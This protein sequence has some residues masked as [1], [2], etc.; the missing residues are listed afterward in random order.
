MQKYLGS[1][2]GTNDFKIQELIRVIDATLGDVNPKGLQT[3]QN[4]LSIIKFLSSFPGLDGFVTTNFLAEIENQV[5]LSATKENVR[6][7]VSKVLM[8]PRNAYLPWIDY[9]CDK[10][11]MTE[12]QQKVSEITFKI[13]IVE[14][15]VYG[16]C[17]S[18]QTLNQIVFAH[19]KDNLPSNL[20]E[21]NETCHVTIINSN[22]VSDVGLEKVESFIQSFDTEF[23]INTGEIKST[24]SEDWSRFS[25]CYVVEITCPYIDSF[26]NSFNET[27]GKNIK[28]AKHITFAIKPRSLWQ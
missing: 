18:K 2:A 4:A 28:I 6:E 23:C 11:L 24:F 15:K 17:Q 13:R 3:G 10:E 5:Q 22:I 1:F 21:N 16:L 14:G 19:L 8:F 20:K 26:L 25:E 12:I 9:P 27:F 7:N